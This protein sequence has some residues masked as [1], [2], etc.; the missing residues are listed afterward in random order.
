MDKTRII[1]ICMMLVILASISV[2][3]EAKTDKTKVIFSDNF[4]GN[5]ISDWN[6]TTNGNADVI[7]DNGAMRLRIY[8]C[9]N[10][11]ASKDLGEVNGNI[12]IDFDWKTL[13]EGWYEVPAYRLLVDGN[14]VMFDYWSC[15]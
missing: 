1:G 2:T 11:Y 9:S 13:S 12:T 8:K 7:A 6:I 3:A 15:S 10:A 4:D 5:D 14:Q